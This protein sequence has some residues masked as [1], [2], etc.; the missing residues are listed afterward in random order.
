MSLAFP[1][2]EWVSAYGTEIFKPAATHTSA[3]G[4]MT[5]IA[6]CNAL[7]PMMRTAAISS[8]L[9]SRTPK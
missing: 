5:L 3:E 4:T 7:A 1:S 6:T 8:W 2:R 9:T